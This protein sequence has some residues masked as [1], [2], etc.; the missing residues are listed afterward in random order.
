[1]NAVK[2]TA[3]F[4]EKFSASNSP[5]TVRRVLRAVGLNELSAHRNFLV[6]GKNRKIRLSFAN[7]SETY[8]NDVLFI[9]VNKFI[10]RF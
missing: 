9:G 1:M 3:E 4:N 8:W 10:F 2:V 5:E 6:S 7:K